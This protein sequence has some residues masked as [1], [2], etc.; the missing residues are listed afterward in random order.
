MCFYLESRIWNP[1]SAAELEEYHY[2]KLCFYLESRI[3]NPESAAELKEYHYTKLCFY[4]ESE[5]G[6]RNQPQSS[7]SIIIRNCVLSGIQNLE[8]GI[9]RR[10][11][12]VS[13]YEIVFLS[14]IQN[15]ES[16]ISRRAQGVS[17][18]EIVF[19]SGIQNRNPESAAELEEYHYP[20]LCFYQE[21]GI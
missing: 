5:S 3:W 9:S 12:G 14:G 4:L 16:G 7:R 15:L 1:E 10:A 6:I 17:L 8:S 2:T 11:R 19:L 21:S 20:K 13:L 18:S